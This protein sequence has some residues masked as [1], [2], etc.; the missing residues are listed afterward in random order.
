MVLLLIFKTQLNAKQP[1]DAELTTL[2]GMQTGTA[3]VL[4]SGTALTS[5]TTELNQ[6][7]GKTLGET[8]LTT[9]SNTA[10][11]T[12]KAVADFVSST[13]SPLGGFEVVATEVLFPNTQ[14]AAGVV[15]IYI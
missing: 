10:I 1:L 15:Y 6:L 9:N 12:S 4:A 14:P 11:P 8:S 2:A 13:I 3:S 7:D 5:T